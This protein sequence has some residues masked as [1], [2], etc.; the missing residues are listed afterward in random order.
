MNGKHDRMM[1][2]ASASFGEFFGGDG[3]K[4]M[5]KDGKQ[6]GK[7]EENHSLTV[8]LG[9]LAVVLSI[10]LIL[11][12]VFI[13]PASKNSQLPSGVGVSS[14]KSS[15]EPAN[16]LSIL[17]KPQN[18]SGALTTEQVAA[19]ILPC[20]VGIIQYQQGSLTETGEGSGII[21]SAD[22]M[23]ITNYHVIEG[24]NRLEIVMQN[25]KKHQA[26][27]VGSDTRTDIAVLKVALSNL[28][29]AQ[30]GD[31]DDSRVGEQV[32]AVGN[33]S[34]LQLAGS[35]TQGIISALNR[36]V[37]VGNGPMNLIQTDAAINPGNS[38]G[39]LVNMYG[40][41]IGINS[42]KIAQMG[43]E[44]LGF[45]IPIKTA[46][47]VIDSI[48]QC[49]YVKGR[50]KFGLSCKEIDSVTAQVNE[51]PVGIYIDYVEP[52]SSAQKNGVLADD[53][54]TA[55]DDTAVKDT[56]SLIVERDKHKAGDEIT[57][58]LYRRSEKKTLSV[59]VTLLEDKGAA[60]S[61][62]KGDW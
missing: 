1:K 21:M 56:D 13:R 53:I 32:I 22:G 36:N 62:D 20:V 2:R 39:A 7:K 61:D 48:L 9:S 19:K 11:M 26:S 12:I 60:A 44:G 50:V 40:Q 6:D 14:V 42:A 49:G 31:S 4:K 51:I 35:V 57:L 18:K 52:G 43:Y 16:S 23:I 29:Y 38:G 30:F 5:K 8:I 24:A 55:I 3:Q 58:S 54:I 28:K 37:D 10:I 59:K 46:K 45:S 27:V 41:V 25:G 33:P 34:G 47:P 15:S 17:K